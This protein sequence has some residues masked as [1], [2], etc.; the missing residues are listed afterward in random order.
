MTSPVLKGFP[1][2]DAAAA[3]FTDA[4]RANDPKAVS[5]L[6][7]DAWVDAVLA[8]AE[9]EK[10]ERL[11][12]LANWDTKHEVTITDGK[13][14]SIVVG[15][16]GWT[17]PVPIVKDGDQWRF[18]STAGDHEMQARQIGHDEMGA[19]QTL[20]AIVAAQHEYAALDPM[21]TGWPQYARR[22][23]S[24]P[25]RKDGLYWPTTAGEAPSPLGE[26]VAASQFDGTAPGAQFG[27]NFRLLYAQGPA[28]T[29]GAHD[30]L[31]N[32]RLIG[33]FG[34]IATPVQYGVTGIMTFIVNYEGIVWQQDLGANT[35]EIAG[36]IASFDPD[37]GWQKA[38]TSP[39]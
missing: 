10:R 16:D 24:S 1:T 15:N 5:A 14:A 6:L 26:V 39:P 2:P 32:G 33:G 36:K 37:K 22:L 19:I 17:F 21:K 38:D 31:V 35:A 28:A 13:R 4:V 18:D 34:A 12:Y 11:A 9:K 27:Y 23:L 20:L 8:D 30:Y 25:G 3:A 29:G 7:G